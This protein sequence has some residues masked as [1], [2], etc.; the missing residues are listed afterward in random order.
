MSGAMHSVLHNLMCN[1]LYIVPNRESCEGKTAVAIFWLELCNIS[2][3]SLDSKLVSAV[4]KPHTLPLTSLALCGDM[5]LTVW[6]SDLEFVNRANLF[7]TN[8]YFRRL[9][10]T[11]IYRCSPATMI[12]AS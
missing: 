1:T 4:H 7:L 5:W 11:G 6:I 12:L 10:Q 8:L 2:A 9:L 3:V